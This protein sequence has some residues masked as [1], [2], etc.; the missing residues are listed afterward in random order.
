MQ[1]IRLAHLSDIHF[2][3]ENEPAV[4]AAREWLCA[5]KVDLAIVSGDLTRFGETTEFA[6]PP[7][8]WTA[9]RDRGW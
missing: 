6:R 7:P 9:C 2:G 8:G 5:E 3:G 4:A 1:T